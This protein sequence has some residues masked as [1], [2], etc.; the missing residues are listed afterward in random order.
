MDEKNLEN[1]KENEKNLSILII[2]SNVNGL[3]SAIKSQKVGIKCIV[4]RVKYFLTTGD[5]PLME[6]VELWSHSLVSI[7]EI[8]LN[9]LNSKKYN[10]SKC[11]QTHTLVSLKNCSS[12]VLHTCENRNYVP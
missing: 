4:S 5:I 3:N 2:N 7:G 8:I 10:L 1:R 6:P 11:T 9:S 12:N